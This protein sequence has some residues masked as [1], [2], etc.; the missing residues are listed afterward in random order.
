M[1][2]AQ[3]VS[4]RS[5]RLLPAYHAQMRLR[6]RSAALIVFKRKDEVSAPWPSPMHR[7]TRGLQVDNDRSLYD[8]RSRTVVATCL[9][10][11]APVL[12]RAS[13]Q[14]CVVLVVA[15]GS[16]RCASL[17]ATLRIPLW[18][19]GSPTGSFK[20]R[21]DATELVERW[22]VLSSTVGQQTLMSTSRL[23]GNE[24]AETRQR[25]DSTNRR[26]SCSGK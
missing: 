16:W 22:R 13:V 7:V 4:E 23:G 9:T 25:G 24:E 15:G 14:L 11:A 18:A 6:A 17:S 2:R 26:R 1:R 19:R 3:T 20:T 8:K 21:G 10:A 12:D 5:F